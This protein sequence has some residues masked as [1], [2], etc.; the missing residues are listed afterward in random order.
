[1]FEPFSYAG[2]NPDEV[3]MRVG[4]LKDFKTFKILSEILE[5]QN[6]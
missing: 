4:N 1:M 6:F 3:E 5:L 2:A